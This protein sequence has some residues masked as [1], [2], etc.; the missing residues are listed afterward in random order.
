MP[1]PYSPQEFE[2]I[3]PTSKFTLCGTGILPVLERGED[4]L[5][6]RSLN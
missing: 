1:N 3:H 4:K 5:N 6:A 2:E